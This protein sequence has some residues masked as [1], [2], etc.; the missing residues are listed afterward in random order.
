MRYDHAVGGLL[1]GF[2]R[3]K[4]KK[5]WGWEEEVWNS[6]RYCGK[7]LHV[8]N[9][10]ECSYH[11]HKVKDE[12]FLVVEGLV[13]LRYSENIFPLPAGKEEASREWLHCPG[14]VLHPGDAFHVPT[15]MRHQFRGMQQ[16]KIIEF[17]THHEDNDTY[18]LLHGTDTDALLSI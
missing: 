11:Y 4:T 9:K 7:I 16:S 10:C 14:I 13:L 17:S 3:L 2:D 18:R 15:F 5:A 8:S 12:T 6:D 1:S